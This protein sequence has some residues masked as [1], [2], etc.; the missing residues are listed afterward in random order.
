MP[1]FGLNLFAA[2]AIFKNPMGMINR[3]ALPFVIV[4]FAALVLTCLPAMLLPG[5]AHW[6]DPGIGPSCFAG[7]RIHLNAST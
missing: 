3:S 5:S 7:T 6:D 4:N 2:R 1:L